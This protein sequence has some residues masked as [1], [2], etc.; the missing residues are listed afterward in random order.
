MFF[1]RHL[2]GFIS[3]AFLISLACAAPTLIIPHTTLN[4]QPLG[5]IEYTLQT[6]D[7]AA[8]PVKVAPKYQKFIGQFFKETGDTIKF[9][10]EGPEIHPAPGPS[11]RL[12]YKMEGG[13]LCGPLN[14][15]FGFVVIPDPSNQNAIF[16]VFIAGSGTEIVSE[17]VK[18]GHDLKYEYQQFL[19]EFAPVKG[20]AW[21][22]P[23]GMCE[24]CVDKM[25]DLCEQCH[26]ERL[27]ES[28]EGRKI[29]QNPWY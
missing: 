20:W 17:T 12:H 4:Q 14:K 2:L 27:E 26:I 8:N 6:L 18:L 22:P 1:T 7:A 5:P 11:A 9:L 29:L 13:K 21:V 25:W 16:G 15:C 19:N 24:K 3:L 23:K 10:N 28:E